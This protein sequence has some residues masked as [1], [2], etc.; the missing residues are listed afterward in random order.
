LAICIHGP[1]GYALAGQGKRFRL[2]VLCELQ[3][4]PIN[5]LKEVR[6]AIES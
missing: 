5:F 3:V 4:L 2:K 1:M 6:E